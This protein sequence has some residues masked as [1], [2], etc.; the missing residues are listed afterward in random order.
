MAPGV[1]RRPQEPSQ[2]A[3]GS[4]QI[5]PWPELRASGGAVIGSTATARPSTPSRG[6]LSVV[7]TCR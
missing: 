3:P 4:I 7:N 1:Y 2:V 6:K 5:R